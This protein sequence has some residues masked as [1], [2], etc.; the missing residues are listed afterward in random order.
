MKNIYSL[1]TAALL[2]I[3]QGVFAQNGDTLGVSP[4]SVP[5][6]A[7]NNEV[8]IIPYSGGWCYG[9]NNDPNVFTR[10]AQGYINDDTASVIGVLSFIPKKAKGPNN[11]PNTKLVFSI[12]NIIPNGAITFSGTPPVITDVRG[13]GPILASVDYFYDEVD[14][15]FGSYNYASF[16]NPVSVSSEIVVIADFSNFKANGDIIAFMSDNV[17]NA[18]GQ[19]LAFHFATGGGANVWLPTNF[20]FQGALDNNVALF[21]VLKGETSGVG[22]FNPTGPTV[23]G[24]KAQL[25]PNP[26]VESAQITI[27]TNKADTYFVD[28]FSLKGQLIS[29]V[30]CGNKPVGQFTQELN[31]EGLSSGTYIYSVRNT[32]GGRYSKSF[33]VK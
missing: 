8:S 7:P 25:F 16:P 32:A 2:I 24:I 12:A 21:P 18:L 33:V 19:D 4:N 3:T 30:N 31:I 22:I 17:G 10:V 14:T 5:Q 23:N 20:V 11:V 1:L 13:P 15:T 26:A 29:T 9:T 27:E 6:F 28:I